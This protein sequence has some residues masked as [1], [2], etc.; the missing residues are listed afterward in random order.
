MNFKFNTNIRFIILF[1]IGIWILCGVSQSKEN[2]GDMVSKVDST[3]LGHG[4]YFLRTVSEGIDSAVYS[5]S[6]K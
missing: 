3:I 4:K 2:A 6:G 5:S 1:V